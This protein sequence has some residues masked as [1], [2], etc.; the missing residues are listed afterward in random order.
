MLILRLWTFTL[1]SLGLFL[2]YGCGE[3]TVVTANVSK[4]ESSQSCIDCHGATVSIITGKSVTDEWKLSAHNLSNKAGCI[5]CHFEAL[6]QSLWHPDC[7]K[8]HGGTPMAGIKGLPPYAIKNPDSYGSCAKCHTAVGGFRITVYDDITTNTRI[9]HFSTPTTAAYTSGRFNARYVTKNYEKSCRSCHN[10]HDTTSRISVLSQ[11]ARSGKGSVSALPW[12]NYDFRGPG[13]GTATPGATPANSFGADCVRCHTA[14]GHINYLANR[15]IAPFGGSSKTEGKE[16]LACNTCH[17]DYSYARRQVAQVTAFYNK[18]TVGKIRIRVPVTYPNIAGSNLCL[19]CHV[20]REIGEIIKELA[21]PVLTS[22]KVTTPDGVYDFSNAPFENSHYLTA[23][24]TIFKTSGFEFY[25]SD[26]Y[27]NPSFYTHDKIGVANFNNT[28]SAG[29]CITCHMKPANH[30]FLPVAKDKNGNITDLTSTA[31]NNALCHNGG[32]RITEIEQ[33][34]ELFNAGMDVLKV[35]L[36]EKLSI[37]FSPNH[38]YFFTTPYDPLYVETYSGLTA[39]S[40]NQPVK[41]WQTNGSSSFIATY[42][43]ATNTRSCVS[44]TL[45]SGIP[46]TGSNNMGAAFNYNL[47][48]N[49]K[50]AFTHN[51]FYVKRLIYDSI[52]WLYDNDVRTINSQSD[53]YFS[54]VEAAIQ[55]SNLAQEVKDKACAYFFTDLASDIFAGRAYTTYRPK[56]RLNWRPGSSVLNPIY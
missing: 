31:C 7:T 56:D 36:K 22:N 1:M 29:P 11:W 25:S 3:K 20:G 37:Y 24:A 40:K 14:T 53:G 26:Y 13:R 50:G 8:C 48:Y 21:N 44:S 12:I 2:L 4:L 45:T 46:R 55:T 19:N 17:I 38:P 39:C 30:T 6:N 9:N 52:S 34:K 33:Q 51:R 27:N 15:S 16:V 35:M 10:P 41:N 32:M 28:G 47:I 18:S 5:D 49:D 43:S 23:G 54:D 42:Y